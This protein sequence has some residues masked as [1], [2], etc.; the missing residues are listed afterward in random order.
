M[1]GLPDL[2][3]EQGQGMEFVA[4]APRCK[5]VHMR[6][7]VYHAFEAATREG[8]AVAVR[9]YCGE[10]GHELKPEDRF[11]SNC[12][13]PI[14]QPTRVPTPEADVPV[15]QPQ[16]QAAQGRQPKARQLNEDTAF[17]LGALVLVGVLFALGLSAQASFW[18]FIVLVLLN[19]FG[20]LLNK[21]QRKRIVSTIPGHT[22]HI[23]QWVKV[24]VAARDGARCVRCASTE[25]IQFDH[26]IPFSRGG[27][28][29]DP[30]NIQ[31]LCGR[32]NRLK[33]NRFIG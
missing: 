15:P 8:V 6:Q 9:H 25:N 27:S 4:S 11:C 12:G 13:S 32:C 30:N 24:Q 29:T 23:P 5:Q 22:R 26:L 33:S 17:V 31:L 2:A 18:V 7:D 3:L 1:A 16:E 21:G 19:F 28:S 10:C 14:Y 20:K